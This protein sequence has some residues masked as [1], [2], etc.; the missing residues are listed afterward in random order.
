MRHGGE[1]LTCKKTMKSNTIKNEI[2]VQTEYM[3]E[4]SG[5]LFFCACSSFFPYNALDEFQNKNPSPYTASGSGYRLLKFNTF[6]L[7]SVRC[8]YDTCTSSRKWKMKIF[9]FAAVAPPPPF[10]L[11]AFL[12][13]C[14]PSPHPFGIRLSAPKLIRSS[15]YAHPP[16]QESTQNP[17]FAGQRA[18]ESRAVRARVHDESWKE[19]PVV[20]SRHVSAVT[21]D[22]RNRTLATAAK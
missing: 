8:Y 9:F 20:P 3:L 1:V 18:G 10:V 12:F 17:V 2:L 13:D 21:S 11:E 16:R 14:T 5:L 4:P 6:P 19:R 7:L 15:H 22:L